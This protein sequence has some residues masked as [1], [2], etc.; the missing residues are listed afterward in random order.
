MGHRDVRMMSREEFEKKI[1]NVLFWNSYRE[2]KEDQGY[3]R[4]GIEFHV[5][6]SNRLLRNNGSPLS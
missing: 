2:T 3:P 1:V 5:R 4:T 6:G